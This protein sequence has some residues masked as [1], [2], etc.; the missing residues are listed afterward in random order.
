MTVRAS[1]RLLP[2]SA[3]ELPPLFFQVQQLDSQS[4]Q[5]I[6]TAGT[7]HVMKSRPLRDMPADN[8][9]KS[10]DVG[11]EV[12]GQQTENMFP[13]VRDASHSVFN[14]LTCTRSLV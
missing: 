12:A 6:E 9:Y 1:Q 8:I 10:K 5:N 7:L 14:L 2:K 13:D 11:V 4:P 3:H